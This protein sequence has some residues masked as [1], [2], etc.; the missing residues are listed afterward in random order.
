MDE[1]V[2]EALEAGIRP[3]LVEY[4]RDSSLG[5]RPFDMEL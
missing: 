5:K 4:A 3:G 2:S 1:C